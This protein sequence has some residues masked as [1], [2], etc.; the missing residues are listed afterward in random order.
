MVFEFHAANSPRLPGS[1]SNSFKIIGSHGV[2]F[3][4]TVR[5]HKSFSCNT[6]GSPRKCCKQNT[7]KK[8]GEGG[9]LPVRSAE[10]P[11]VTSLLLYLLT[12]SFLLTWSHHP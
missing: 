12:S 4:P 6:Y 2:T 7:Y 1:P 3:S 9:A 10:R 11:F 8:Q 5:L